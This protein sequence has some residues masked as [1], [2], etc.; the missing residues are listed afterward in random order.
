MKI[1]SNA[2]SIDYASHSLPYLSYSLSDMSVGAF[3]A[4]LMSCYRVGITFVELEHLEKPICTRHATLTQ[5][6][7]NSELLYLK[8]TLTLDMGP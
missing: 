1:A 5:D 6:D 7:P 4:L 3:G 2:I 8:M